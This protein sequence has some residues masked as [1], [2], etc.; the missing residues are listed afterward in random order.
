MRVRK[1]TCNE[2]IFV[3]HVF[4]KWFISGTGS[5]TVLVTYSHLIGKKVLLEHNH[6]HLFV[7]CLW[8]LIYYIK[9]VE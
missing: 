5:V 7:Y 9:R 6:R 1:E 4:D 3:I 2:K 8:L